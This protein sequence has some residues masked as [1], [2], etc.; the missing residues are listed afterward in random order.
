VGRVWRYQN[1]NQ[2]QKHNGQKKKDKQRSTNHTDKTKDQVT[3]TP[4]KTGGEHWCSWKVNSFCST[5]GTRRVSLVTNPVY[6][7]CFVR[8]NASLPLNKSPISSRN[9]FY[10]LP[11]NKS[12]ISSRNNFYN[13][14]LNKSPIS[15]KNNLYNLPLNKSTIS[16]R[17]NFYNLPLNKSPISSRNNFYNLPLNKSPISSRTFITYH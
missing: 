7:S 1:A 6:S 14:P 2:N 3:Q 11:L 15:S 10:N 12:P 4:L 9:N 16:S 13:L 5:S 17:N 8:I